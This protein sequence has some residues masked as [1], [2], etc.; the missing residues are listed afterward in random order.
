[1]IC[2]E[3][4]FVYGDD[5]DLERVILH[6]DA[7][8]FY[9]SV[10]CV[11]HPD[12]RGKP[13]AVCG[14]AEMRHGIVLAST[15][16]A[17][18]YGIKTGMV[19]WQA[20]QLCPSLIV[21]P[22]HST[23][24]SQYS[25]RLRN[26]FFDYTDR[27]EPYGLDECWLDVSDPKS[28]IHNGSLLADKLR[29]RVK[30]ELEITISA[31]V[32]FNKPF[33]KLASDLKKP[34]ATTVI[35]QDNYKE[36]VWRL[37]ISSLLFVGPK[38][39]RKLMDRCIYTIG[40]LAKADPDQ[41][42]QLLGKNGLFLIAYANGYD[43]SPVKRMEDTPPIKSV[44]NSITTPRDMETI[45]DVK[46]VLYLLA[47]SVAMRLREQN[48][49]GRCVSISIRDVKLAWVSCQKTLPFST[50]LEDEIYSNAMA[51]FTERHTKL[52]PLRSIGV[53]VSQLES[54]A[55]PVQLDM[56]G[57]AGR[58]EEKLSLVKT[59]DQLRQQYGPY[60][61][62]RGLIMADTLFS[63]LNPKEEHMNPIQGG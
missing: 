39:T 40:D 58:R 17:K 57:N 26:I 10:E 49:R 43:L 2:G 54:D 15:K 11:F 13:M 25:N 62:Q 44:G 32:S 27:V 61:I 24:Y 16:E 59:I 63:K 12:W 22:A 20:K 47:E 33:A 41:M 18:Q 42:K 8:S 19:T 23:L 38:T 14:N 3:H 28:T 36:T 21:S 4:V 53:S 51:L 9:A 30:K 34:D 55:A 37:P 46:C 31:G 29:E 52:L 5:A 6:C 50:N 60:I 35:S 56:F 45:E 1:M 7:N 48:Y